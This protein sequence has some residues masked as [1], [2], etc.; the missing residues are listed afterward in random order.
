MIR[1]ATLIFK[2]WGRLT[3]MVVLMAGVLALFTFPVKA[4]DISLVEL[5]VLDDLDAN[6]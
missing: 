6:G 2:R 3:G 4:D 1:L 5:E